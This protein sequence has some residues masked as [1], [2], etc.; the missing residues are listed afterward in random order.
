MALATLSTCR[1]DGREGVASLH[2]IRKRPT[3]A[4]P[5][6]QVEF[7]VPFQKTTL[8]HWW[9]DLSFPEPISRRSDVRIVPSAPPGRRP[10]AGQRS[11]IPPTVV[12]FHPPLLAP[13]AHEA[14]Q[15]FCKPPVAGSNPCQG[16]QCLRSSVWSEQPALNRMAG[17]S[18][19]SGGTIHA[20]VP[21]KA[22]G[23][24]F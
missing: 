15:W 3:N 17:G 7:E 16:L 18:N 5:W 22:S 23:P 13:E 9:V 12:R 4:P 2:C 21:V 11:Y 19:P 1:E 24:G 8:G 14:E 6:A 10:M 20:G